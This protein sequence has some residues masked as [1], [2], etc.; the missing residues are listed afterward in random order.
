MQ[1]VSEIRCP[2]GR[3]L[4]VP[5]HQYFSMCYNI[6]TQCDQIAKERTKKTDEYSL[7]GPWS[8]DA[9]EDLTPRRM[10]GPIETIQCT[11]KAKDRTR[12]FIYSN[13]SA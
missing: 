2:V 12:L 6:Y 5:F 4:L 8:N 1:F 3:P 13:S 9:N 11:L 7:Q 10:T